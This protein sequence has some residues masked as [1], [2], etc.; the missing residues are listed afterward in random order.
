VRENQQYFLDHAQPK[1]RTMKLWVGTEEITAELALTATQIATGMMFRETMAEDEGMLF[2][3]GTPHRTSFYMKNT[4]IPLSGAYIDT[5]GVIAE[6]VNLKP[7]DETPVEA[8]SD[9]IQYVLEVNQGWFQRHNIGAGT[10]IRS[11]RGSLPDTFFR[12][13]N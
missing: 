12:R 10:V 7:L 1:L 2:V 5:N 13:R 9:N 3:F 4:K 6:I 8:A 11:E